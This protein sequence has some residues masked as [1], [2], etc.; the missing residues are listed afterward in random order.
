MEQVELKA[1]IRKEIGKEAARL[2]RQ[3]GLIPAVVYGAAAETINIKVGARDFEKALHTSAGENVLVNLKLAGAGRKAERT[4]IIKEIQY[5]PVK[6]DI[7]HLDFKHISLKEAI[8]VKVPVATKGESPGVKEGGS[9]EQILW[10]VEVECL[11]TQIPE[12]I[13]VE[14][15]DLKIGDAVHVKELDFP[16]GVEVLNPPE[17]V[18]VSCVPPKVVVEEVVPA[19]EEV[20]EPEVIGKKKEEEVPE[21]APEEEAKPKKEAKPEKE[22]KPK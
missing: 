8:K 18:V 4:V 17:D 5:D 21:E 19:A 16:E 11:P 3:Q 6:G 20:A 12:K 10:E 1:E 2:L 7:Y 15:S 14:L 9:I 22:A 13:E